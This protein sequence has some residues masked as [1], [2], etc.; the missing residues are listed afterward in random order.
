MWLKKNTQAEIKT[1]EIG[2]GRQMKIN[3]RSKLD[4]TFDSISIGWRCFRLLFSFFFFFGFAQWL[5]H[6]FCVVGECSSAR[7]IRHSTWQPMNGFWRFRW[8]DIDRCH[9]RLIKFVR[10]LYIDQSKSMFFFTFKNLNSID[11]KPSSLKWPVICQ[12]VKIT[13][14]KK[15]RSTEFCVC[16]CVCGFFLVCFFVSNEFMCLDFFVWCFNSTLGVA[17]H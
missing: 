6:R 2:S 5:S 13:H 8:I 12:Q 17:V 9:L 7:K 14:E 15:M 4:S 3:N 11:A 16:A 1:P 10:M